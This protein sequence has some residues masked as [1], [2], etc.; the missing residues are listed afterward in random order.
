PVTKAGPVTLI[1]Q[2]RPPRCPSDGAASAARSDQDELASA[3]AGAPFCGVVRRNRQVGAV[4]DGDD[5]LGGDALVH[6][7][8]PHCIRAL[9]RQAGVPDRFPTLIAVATDLQPGLG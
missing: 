1:V 8:P 3:V 7:V 2:D 5:A 9:A 6:Q 4:A